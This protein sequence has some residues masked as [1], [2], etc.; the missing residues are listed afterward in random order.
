MNVFSKVAGYKCATMLKMNF[1]YRYFSRTL[2]AYFI[3]QK[4]RT[5]NT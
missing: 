5:A 3:W 1:F 4:F 2:T